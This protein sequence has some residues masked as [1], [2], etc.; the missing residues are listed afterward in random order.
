[1]RRAD[2]PTIIY[3]AGALIAAVDPAV[4]IVFS[5]LAFGEGRDSMRLLGREYRRPD[6]WLAYDEAYRAFGHVPNTSWVRPSPPPQ[7]NLPVFRLPQ[8]I[9]ETPV[10]LSAGRGAR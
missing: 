7:E 9:D 10:E 8:L 2:L 5:P 4:E 3:D 6:V 1:V